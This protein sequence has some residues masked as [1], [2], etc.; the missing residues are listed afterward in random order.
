M[1]SSVFPASK[2]IARGREGRSA[3][4]RASLP[5]R[6]E[7]AVTG[8]DTRQDDPPRRA[9]APDRA[10]RADARDRAG[11]APVATGQRSGDLDVR[12][13]EVPAGLHALPVRQSR[14]PQG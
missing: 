3:M 4:T 13:S 11:P 14:R 12:G 6:L 1:R 10:A 9:P 8:W 5:P 7:K 2:K